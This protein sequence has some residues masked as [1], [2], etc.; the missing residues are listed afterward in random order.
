MLKFLK[1]RS[2]F[3]TIFIGYIIAI[4]LI[5]ILAYSLVSNYIIDSSFRQVEPNLINQ[6]TII[7]NLTDAEELG[8]ASK[9]ES[10]SK[11]F[12]ERLTVIDSAGIVIYD[13]KADA[14]LME[15]HLNRPEILQANHDNFGIKRRFSQ[16]IDKEMIYAAIKM[17]Y[18]G[19]LTGYIRLSLSIKSHEELMSDILN[20]FLQAFLFAGLLGLLIAF[21]YSGRLARRIMDVSDY[22]VAIANDDPNY[23]AKFSLNGPRELNVLVQALES[24]AK[25]TKGLLKKVSRERRKLK[26]IIE[27]ITQGLV[28]ISKNNKIFI[29]NIRAK[30]ILQTESP[31]GKK[32]QLS[33]KDKTLLKGIKKVKDSNK[34][35]K[36]NWQQGDEYFD[37]H[38]KYFPRSKETFIIFND[39]T[40]LKD[41]E[42]TKKQFVANVSHELRTPLTAMKG[43]L[44]SMDENSPLL[45]KHLNIIRRNTDRM[46]SMVEDLLSLARM[47]GKSAQLEFEEFDMPKLV[48]Q[49]MDLF[50][51]QSGEKS[52]DVTADMPE[53]MMIY[54]DPFKIEE[55]LFNLLSNAIKYTEKGQVVVGVKT[56]GEKSVQITVKDSGIGIAK[57]M[58]D[59]IFERFFVVSKSRTRKK[60][61]TGLGLAIVKH[62][63]KLHEGEIAVKSELG[64]GSEFIITLPQNIELKLHL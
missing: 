37:V 64:N 35:Y 44:E 59:K 14:A 27:D 21:I 40:E 36:I 32:Y 23:E 2:I 30:E 6:L 58:Q 20:T 24:M 17:E 13:S 63:V 12:N 5:L 29:A 1:K 52:I 33:I 4:G 50:V 62:I 15:N 19:K 57:E 60:G 53:S 22:A 7:S 45:N 8:P 16:T 9:W 41:L 48:R 34:I 25:Q 46:I 55:L 28:V 39:I 61:G 56:S 10:F 47:E 43:F 3:Q 51:Q 11:R 18:E 49:T 26:G 31:E 38:I 42:L 54:A